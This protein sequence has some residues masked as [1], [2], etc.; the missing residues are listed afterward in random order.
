MPNNDAQKCSMIY[1]KTQLFQ[2]T[3]NQL[4][5]KKSHSLQHPLQILAQNL[6]H[7]RDPPLR[8]ALHNLI[9]ILPQLANKRQHLGQ[10]AQPL[11]AKSLSKLLLAQHGGEAR[12]RVLV[13]HV[14]QQHGVHLAVVVE[15][16]RGGGGEV[17]DGGDDVC[18][19]VVC[20]LDGEECEE[21]WHDDAI[22]GGRLPE[23]V[24]VVLEGFLEG[25]EYGAAEGRAGG[26]AGELG[27]LFG[28]VVDDVAGV[29]CDD[30]LVYV[31]NVGTAEGRYTY[32]E[33][34][35]EGSQE[36]V[37]SDSTLRLLLDGTLLI[38]QLDEEGTE[39]GIVQLQNHRNNGLN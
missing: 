27:E 32:L 8:L 29:C 26:G 2:P 9:V 18:R 14:A 39:S 31:S 1:N 5:A 15:R 28:G 21:G 38:D 25:G 16:R 35:E 11:L 13:A 20:G 7:T 33:L 22:V 23:A 30:G 19:D 12:V 37:E 24:L 3:P 10:Q 17:R 36:A 4:T 6:L 34:V